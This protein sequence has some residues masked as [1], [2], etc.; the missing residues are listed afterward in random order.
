M[1]FNFLG[2]AREVGKSAV[3]VEAGGKRVLLDYGVKLFGGGI[4]Y[5]AGVKKL[6]AA[7]IS[8]AHLDHSGS[9]PAIYDKHEVPWFGTFPTQALSDILIHDSVKVQKGQVPFALASIKRAGKNFVPLQYKV[10]YHFD[11]GFEITLHDAGHIPGAAMVELNAEGKRILYTGDYKLGDTR[12]HEA[13]KTVKDVDY[14]ITE[15]TYSEREHPDRRKAEEQ[16]YKRVM[17]AVD[18]GGTALLPCFAVGRSQEIMRVIRAFDK[19]V[20][21][22]FDGMAK[23]ATEVIMDYPSYYR[24]PD[25]LSEAA[26]SI[27]WVYSA[28]QRGKAVAGGGVI[29]STAGMLTGGPVL[30]YIRNINAESTITLTGYGVQETNAWYLLNKQMVIIDGREIPIRN[31]V[32]YIDFSAH[33][34]G[35]E[36]IKFVEKANPQK[37]FCIHG[38]HCPEFAAKLK[39]RGFDAY[40]PELDEKFVCD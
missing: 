8:H 21:I 30:W 32:E 19:H 13:A 4:T 9:L 37:V 7:I 6:D 15:S 25:E 40:A 12:M 11:K 31:S 38:D 10:P 24:K 3:F 33:A 1:E 39:E 16:L 14:L 29:I 36:L 27:E 28:K 35:S 17:Q 22:F 23:A 18:A 5:P 34:S 2:A 26:E 20:P